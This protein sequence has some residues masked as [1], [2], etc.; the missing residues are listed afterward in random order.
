MQSRL[1]LH[2]DLNECRLEDR[3]LLAAPGQYTVAP[4]FQINPTSNQ[5]IVPGTST[6]GGSSTTVGPQFF[7]LLIGVNSSGGGSFSIGSTVSVYGLARPAGNGANVSIGSGSNDSGGGGGSVGGLSNF[8]GQGGTFS[9]GYNTS[10]NITNNFGLSSNAVGSMP[11][12]TFDNGSPPVPQTTQANM[13]TT[14]DPNSTPAPAA[15]SMTTMGNRLLGKK[16]GTANSLI[17][18]PGQSQSPNP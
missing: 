17:S 6:S 4:F 14:T 9:S 8:G 11:V 15:N 10:L 12:H 3:T 1:A 16:L 2:P 13:G 5:F 18:G 7:Y